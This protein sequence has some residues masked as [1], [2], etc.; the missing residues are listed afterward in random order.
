MT[1]VFAFWF[2][3]VWWSGGDLGCV[4]LRHLCRLS[5]VWQHAKQIE[6][7]ISNNLD[8]ET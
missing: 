7:P 3:M 6:P 4:F 2:L 1:G 5:A 8:G